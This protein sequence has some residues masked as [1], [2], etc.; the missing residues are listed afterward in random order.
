M[1]E[2]MLMGRWAVRRRQGLM[3]SGV[4]RV[5]MGCGALVCDRVLVRCVRM[6]RRRMCVSWRSMR[7]RWQRVRVRRW[8]VRRWGMGG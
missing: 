4:R 1:R 2:D 6:R 3:R 7:M 5:F 8:V